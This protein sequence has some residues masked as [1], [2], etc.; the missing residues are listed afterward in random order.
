MRNLQ[1]LFLANILLFLCGAC[2][3][4]T[5]PMGGPKDIKPPILVKSNPTHNQ[6]NFHSKTLV[7]TFNEAV[8]LKNPKEE[9]IITPSPG[10]DIDIKAK[11][12]SVTIEPKDGWKDSTTYNLS[13]R[14]AVQDITEGNPALNLRLAFSTGPII[15]SLS[16]TGNIK[17]ALS[18]KIPELTTVALHTQDTFDIFKHTPTYFTKANKKGEFRLDNLKAGNYFIYAFDD[19]NKNL[20]VDSQNE[21]FAFKSKSINLTTKT[22]KITLSLIKIDTRKLK[23]TSSRSVADLAT[24]KLSKAITSYNLKATKTETPPHS[25]GSNQSEIY[26]YLPKELTDSLQV[27][28]IGFDSLAQ[29]IDTTI[30]LKKSVAKRQPEK[31]NV[32]F[33]TPVLETE[34][35]I[36]KSTFKSTKLITGFNLDS[37]RILIDSANY[38]LFSKTDFQVDTL[39]NKGTV[40][41][42]I[43]KTKITEVKKGITKLLL[44]KDYIHSIENDSIKGTSIPIAVLTLEDTGTLL[45]EVKPKTNDPFLIQLLSPDNKVVRSIANLKKY[46]FKYLEPNTFKIRVV[47]DKNNNGK[48]DIGNVLMKEEPEPIFFYQNADKKYDFP[49]RAN[50]EVGPYT[51]TF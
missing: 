16:I 15:D 25:F 6:K 14:E 21:H 37:V 2:A 1:N 5:T 43:E 17:Y 13:F 50:W 27:R 26:T 45:I 20:K 39:E 18:E 7:L 4:Q 8:V 34:T 12:N 33:T 22:E 31:F 35:G 47:I 49:I 41:K 40:S 9:I 38:I 11:G 10:K 3:T 48:W 36:L 19:N 44:G 24:I 32:A 42:S 28:V 30:F 29:K 51:I 23:I 46:S